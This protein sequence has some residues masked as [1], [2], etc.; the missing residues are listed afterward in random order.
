MESSG[1]AQ[2]D[3][4]NVAPFVDRSRV[5]LAAKI[6]VWHCYRS[7]L[8]PTDDQFDSHEIKQ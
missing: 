6:K 2:V 8:I 4:W 1:G 5:R 3:P 7:K